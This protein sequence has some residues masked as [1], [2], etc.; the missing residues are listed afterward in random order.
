MNKLKDDHK[1]MIVISSRLLND[2]LTGQIESIREDLVLFRRVFQGHILMES[3]RF[4]V[5]LTGCS[6]SIDPS[7]TKRVPCART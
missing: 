1:E 5:S 4:Y 7:V 6:P 3:V 2:A